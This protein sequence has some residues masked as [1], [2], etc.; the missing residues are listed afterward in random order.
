[1]ASSIILS[2]SA[3]PGAFGFCFGL[4]CAKENWQTKINKLVS[5]KYF[6]ITVILYTRCLV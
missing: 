3:W 4:G 5:V 2:I 6:F 1:M